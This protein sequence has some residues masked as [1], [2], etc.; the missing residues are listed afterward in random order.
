MIDVE[1]LAVQVGTLEFPELDMR[2]FGGVVEQP[3]LWAN[4]GAH[5]GIE[6]DHLAVGIDIRI[7]P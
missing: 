3:P 5:H 4:V 1:R 2:R 7:D 6:K